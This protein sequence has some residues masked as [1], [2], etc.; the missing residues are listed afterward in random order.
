MSR[1]QEL[2]GLKQVWRKRQDASRGVR[3]LQ[4][5][6]EHASIRGPAGN[7]TCGGGG[8]SRSVL[9]SRDPIGNVTCGGA[10]SA[11]AFYSLG[12]L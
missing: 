1:A 4:S 7:V 6:Q 9:S 10:G 8:V 2:R 12:A 3:H 5:W 11:G